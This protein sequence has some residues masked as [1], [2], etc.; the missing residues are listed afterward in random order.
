MGGLAFAPASESV[1]RFTDH[2][3][4]THALFRGAFSG[5]FTSEA[6]AEARGHSLAWLPPC[7]TCLC[8]SQDRCMLHCVMIRSS[9]DSMIPVRCMRSCLVIWTVSCLDVRVPCVAHMG[10]GCVVKRSAE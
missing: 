3:M 7:F 6:E 1:L 10:L 4:R 5:V 2:M 9:T 8:V